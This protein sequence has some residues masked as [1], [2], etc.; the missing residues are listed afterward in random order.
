MQEHYKDCTQAYFTTQFK[1]QYFKT[2]SG[3]DNFQ[4]LFTWFNVTISAD[5]SFGEM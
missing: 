5:I 1:T 2:P 4:F 3:H